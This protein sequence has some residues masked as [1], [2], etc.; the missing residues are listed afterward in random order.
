MFMNEPHN[1]YEPFTKYYKHQLQVYSKQLLNT[2]FINYCIIC[3]QSIN[4]LPK[5]D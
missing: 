2:L 1:T 3:S 4:Y 5:S